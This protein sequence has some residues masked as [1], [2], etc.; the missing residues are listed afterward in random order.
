[1]S[2]RLRL[3]SANYFFPKLLIVAFK[4]F[5][6]AE[7]LVKVH[8]GMGD[9]MAVIVRMAR[10]VLNDDAQNTPDELNVGSKCAEG[11]KDGSD[12]QL[13][14]VEAFAEHLH[15]YDAVEFTAGE[16]ALHVGLFV[17]I[18]LAVNEI[19]LK[20]SRLIHPH[21]LASMVNAAGDRDQLM[22]R[23]GFP[24]LF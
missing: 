16:A 2:R 18:H 13:R 12:T 7:P 8:A 14:V 15:L 21:D 1:M 23:S 4:Q 17:L 22:R 11:P 9:D 19:S 10:A 3:L 6:L 5:E 24:E 20:A